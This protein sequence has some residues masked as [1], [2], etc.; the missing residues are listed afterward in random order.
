[1]ERGLA[2]LNELYNCEVWAIIECNFLAVVATVTRVFYDAP[3]VEEFI[4]VCVQLSGATLDRPVT[5]LVSTEDDTAEGN[6]QYNKIMF[7]TGHLTY[8]VSARVGGAQ[9]S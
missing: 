7:G 5:V 4:N 6:I 1:M 9:W 3:E 2:I 8:E